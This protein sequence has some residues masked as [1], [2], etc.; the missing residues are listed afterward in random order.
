M[1]KDDTESFPEFDLIHS[2]TRQQA[3]EDGVLVDVTETAREAGFRYPVA[4]TAAVFGSYVEA[5]AGVPGQDA[6]G[7]LW[8][9][10]W[11]LRHA[12]RGSS[13]SGSKLRFQLHVQNTASAPPQLVTLKSVCGPGDDGEPVITIMLPDED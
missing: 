2:Y 3:I 6:A 8:D 5:P 13:G 7:R 9:I 1:T 10:L 11:M 12:I 4:M